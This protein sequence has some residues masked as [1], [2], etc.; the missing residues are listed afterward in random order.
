[1]TPTPFTQSQLQT[2]GAAAI[3]Y[4]AGFTAGADDRVVCEELADSGHLERIAGVDLKGT[5]LEG[6]VYRLSRGYA[7]AVAI[8]ANR[9]AEQ[10][11]LN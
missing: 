2:L 6:P 9:G 11:G 3:L 4:P 5:G 10:A 7:E 8:V 1:M